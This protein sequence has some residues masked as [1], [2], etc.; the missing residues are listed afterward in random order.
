MINTKYFFQNFKLPTFLFH[1]FLITLFFIPFSCLYGQKEKTTLIN[2][3]I[4][5]GINIA[6]N[7]LSKE[8]TEEGWELLWDGKTTTGWRSIKTK[9]F[10]EKG[11]IIENG[12]LTVEESGRG[13]SIITKE[14]YSDFELKLEVK[15]TSGANSGIKY[16]VLE[17]LSSPGSGIGLEYQILDDENH[18][19]AKEGIRIG[20]RTFGSLYDLIAPEAKTVLPVGQWN[21]VQIVSGG[22]H[23]EH[24]LNGKK[25]L[26]YERGS[27]QYRKLV[28]DS[29]YKNIPGFGEASEGHILLQD[30]GNRV[31]FRNIKIRVLK[32]E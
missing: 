22:N 25:V 15:I 12:T 16:F 3:S 29:K 5:Q 31:S 8:E 27:E 11:W 32:P 17:E 7:K 14:K 21:S 18:P 20:S 13:G 1:F 9:S 4:D 23:I 26:E 24:W 28:L 6:L 30:H 19:D 2:D 10:P